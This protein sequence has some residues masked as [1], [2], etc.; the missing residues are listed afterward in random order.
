MYEEVWQCESLE[1][2][3]GGVRLSKS[4]SGTSSQLRLSRFAPFPTLSNN[5]PILFLLLL[6]YPLGC[7]RESAVCAWRS[8]PRP[9]LAGPGAGPG[10]SAGDPAPGA[11][12]RPHVVRPRRYWW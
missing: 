6:F 10:E 11:L 3:R 9:Q 5:S 2:L 4:C 7:G 12:L 1:V 8:L